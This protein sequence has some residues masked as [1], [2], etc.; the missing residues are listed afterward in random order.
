M[1]KTCLKIKIFSGMLCVGLAFSSTGVSFASVT[2]NEITTAVTSMDVKI[3]SYDKKAAKARQVEMKATLDIVIKES[4]TSSIITKTEGDKVLK[5]VTVKSEKNLNIK[6]DKKDKNGKCDCVKGGLFNDLVT[7]GILT[8]E[9]SDALRKKMYSKKTEI[10]NTELKNGLNILVVNKILTSEQSKKVYVV[11]INRQKERKETYIKAK[12]MSEKERKIY[13]EKMK[14]TRVSP[15]KV[16]IDN[17]TITKEQEIEIIKV[18][19]HH[20]HGGHS[21]K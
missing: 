3:H 8:Q 1:K 4:I 10:R 18:L 13:M 7:D 6:K 11:I 17:G 16:L 19:P 15:M 20:F 12:N 21:N 5:Y 2:N 9:K 14:L